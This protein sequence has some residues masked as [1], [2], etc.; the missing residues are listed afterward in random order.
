M[1]KAEHPSAISDSFPRK[2]SWA[3]CYLYLAL[4]VAWVL[5]MLVP[6]IGRK[7][8]I[9]VDWS[10]ILAPTLLFLALGVSARWAGFVL[11]QDCQSSL[12][13]RPAAVLRSAL[14]VSASLAGMLLLI[15]VI[16][17]FLFDLPLGVVFIAPSAVFI[18]FLLFSFLMHWLIATIVF[19]KSRRHA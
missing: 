13:V 15:L 2:T 9:G 11:G 10:N 8:A 5:V 14:I 17:L 12:R 3:I 19:K 1:T 6:I 7:G 18:E 16:G 4:F